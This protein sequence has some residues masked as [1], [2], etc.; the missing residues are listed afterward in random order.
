[1]CA[2]G[3]NALNDIEFSGACRRGCWMGT[4][5]GWEKE[6]TKRTNKGQETELD[7]KETRSEEE[8]KVDGTSYRKA[9]IR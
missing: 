6:E 2:Q 4:P 5:N 9:K 3:G 7:Q 8:E 1:M